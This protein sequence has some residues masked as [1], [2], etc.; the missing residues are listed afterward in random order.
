MSSQARQQR[1]AYEKWLKKTDPIRYKEWKSAS[2]ERGKKLHFDNVEKARQ[3]E[4]E[5]YEKTQ[6]KMIESL[7]EKGLT[8]SEID[9]QIENWTKTINVWGS[10]ERPARQREIRRERVEIDKST[11]IE[12]E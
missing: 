3:S 4:T 1:R 5:F 8:D 2:Q 11:E 12:G 10:N 9:E 7:R 6:T